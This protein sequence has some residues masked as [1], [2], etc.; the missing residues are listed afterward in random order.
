MNT[1]TK[2]L[3]HIA[4]IMDGNGRWAER[5]GLSRIEGHEAGA[6]NV[7]RIVKVCL[8]HKIKFLT[9]Y[10]FST[11][12]WKRPRD[13]INS[14]LDLLL[15]FIKTETDDF[16]KNGIRLLVS[17]DISKFSLRLQNEIKR[18][19]ELTK[20]NKALTVN[21]AL[22]YGGRDEILRAVKNI[23]SDYL[24]KKI[25]MDQIDEKLFSK[26]LYNGNILPEPDLLI[27]TSGEYRISNFLLWQIAYTELYFTKTL[28]PD[29][30][31]RKFETAISNYYKRERRFGGR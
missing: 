14:L 29:F 1:R 18:V 12:N 21:I 22:N 4:I 20:D 2:K 15:K 17:G 27:R 7:K 10:A 26:Y 16:V 8:R 24:S 30:N 19:I 6:Q 28:W 5:K 25:K 3:V 13:E 9:L 31:E 11:E 23:I